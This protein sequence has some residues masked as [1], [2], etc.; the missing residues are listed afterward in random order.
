MLNLFANICRSES[1]RNVNRFPML[2]LWVCMHIVC[3][4]PS[5]FLKCY[6]YHTSNKHHRYADHKFVQTNVIDGVCVCTVASTVDVFTKKKKKNRRIQ[7]CNSVC[8]RSFRTYTHRSAPRD[9]MEEIH[10][11]PQAMHFV[12]FNLR[13]WKWTVCTSRWINSVW[14][15]N[16]Q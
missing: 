8:S 16:I 6:F 14:M 1:E 4:E 7:K 5:K 9:R 12:R 10:N 3:M 15:L 13:V 11:L 2:H